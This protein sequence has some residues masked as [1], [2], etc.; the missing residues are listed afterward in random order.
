[1]GAPALKLQQIP[2]WVAC[3]ADYEPLA[4]ERLTDA[5]WAYLAGGAADELTLQDNIAAFQRLR[6]RSRVLEDLTGGNTRLSLFGQ[7]LE[8]PILLGP[9]AHQGL[10]DPDA[11][12]AT[13]L[14]A[15]ATGTAC[16]VSTLSNIPLEEIA[17][18]AAAR[19]GSS[20]MSSTT[21]ASPANWCSAPRLPAMAPSSSPSMRR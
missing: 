20:S 2:H 1:M 15:G 18:R 17:A 8:S 6:L 9:V 14:A 12:H 11:E 19:S 4:R 5:A 10:F 3:A 21:A 13:V 16:V 7:T